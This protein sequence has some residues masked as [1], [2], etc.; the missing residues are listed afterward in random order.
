MTKSLVQGCSAL[1]TQGG[2]MTP[3]K[4]SILA[5]LLVVLLGSRC[6]NPFLPFADVQVTGVKG[7]VQDVGGVPS[8]T[9]R[10][11]VAETE[12]IGVSITTIMIDLYDGSGMSLGY[13]FGDVSEVIGLSP[14]LEANKSRTCNVYIDK[15]LVPGSPVTLKLTVKW[16]DDNKYNGST[17]ASGSFS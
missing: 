12:G 2:A 9:V 5:A 3:S 16:R 15:S 8:Y 6:K 10:F 17:E 1:G 11:E 4:M 14:R 13:F 7:Y